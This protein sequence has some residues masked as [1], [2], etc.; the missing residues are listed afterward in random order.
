M[1]RGKKFNESLVAEF[2]G[3]YMEAGN[4]N[5]RSDAIRWFQ[6]MTG[7]SPSTARRVL[8]EVTSS[9][10][11]CLEVAERKQRRK[12]R[13]TDIQ[14]AEEKRHAHA[15]AAFKRL[16]GDGR[17]KWIPTERAITMAENTGLIPA[18]RYTRATM[19]R[20]LEREG[21]NKRQTNIGTTAH[22]ITAEYPGQVLVVDA[23]PMDQYYLKLDG[24]VLRYHTPEGDKHLDDLLHREHLVKIW[25]YY[26]VDMYSKAFLAMPFARL[27]REGRRNSGE[28]A[29][30]WYEFLKWVILPKSG[31]SP[32]QGRP[33]P[34]ADCPFEGIPDVIYCDKG[35]GIGKSTLINETMANLGPRIVTHF[36]GNP[37][38]KGMVEG[39]IS[40]FKRS[41]EVGFIPHTIT[42]VNELMYIYQAWVN[43]FNKT[44]MYYDKWRAGVKSNPILRATEED[45][46]HASVKS[47]TRTITQYGTVSLEKKDFFVHYDERYLHTKVTVYRPKTRDGGY[48]YTARLYDGKIVELVEGRP[49]HAFNDIKSHK[50]SHGAANREEVKR[51]SAQLSNIITFDT[52]LPPD[53]SDNIVSFPQKFRQAEIAPS[54]IA[55]P[56]F[57]TIDSAWKWMLNR[58]G[59]FMEEIPDDCVSAVSTIL[60]AAFDKDRFISGEAATTIASII[61]KNKTAE[62]S[63]NEL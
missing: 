29:D 63:T 55:P 35:S 12:S 36:P 51:L 19:D 37:S 27:P 32:I 3:K 44:R 5:E 50:K 56:V 54:I 16:P 57:D 17:K 18:G 15:V 41:A 14:L 2:A 45:F 40:A 46:H 33:A 58:T 59:L 24:K 48:R 22:G 60:Q 39:R 61:E 49:E 20:L 7:V 23:T 53:L 42:N 25:V 38:A 13:K 6:S 34:F 8:S 4:R 31:I 1:P 21:L 47:T 11:S 52:T 43:Y 30:D 28:N 62:V 26:A 9:G 10:K